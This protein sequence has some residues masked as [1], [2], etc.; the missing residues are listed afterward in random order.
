MFTSAVAIYKG[1][2]KTLRI[3]VRDKLKQPIDLSAAIIRSMVKVVASDVDAIISK[4]SSV[5][6]NQALVLDQN[7][8][9]TKGM[10]ELYY[11]PD[12]TLDMDVLVGNYVWDVWVIFPATLTTPLRQYPVIKEGTFEIAETVTNLEGGG[13]GP[14]GPP[15]NLGGGKD[16]YSEYTCTTGTAIH[17]WV[18]ETTPGN[19][20]PAN[21]T[22]ASKMPAIGLVISKPTTTL[23]V[24]RWAGEETGFVGLG[25]GPYYVATVDGQMTTTEPSATGNIVQVIGHAQSVT[26]FLVELSEFTVE[27]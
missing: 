27:L 22:N 11:V 7:D 25:S 6:T 17:D 21:A 14:G 15:P 26:V 18:Y 16:D 23:A 8:P 4:D 13:G 1:Q 10:F 2:S 19:V 3:T 12:D 24:V 9:D 20:A 5:N